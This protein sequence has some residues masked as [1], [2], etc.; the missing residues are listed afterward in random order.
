M[1]LHDA[2]RDA[3]LDQAGD[4]ILLEEQDR[5]RFNRAQITEALPLVD[6]A[7]R[8]GPEPF[9]IEAAIAA[10]HCRAETAEQTDWPQ[11]LGLYDVLGRLQPSPVVSLNRAVALAMVRGVKPALAVVDA[12]ANNSDLDNYYLLYATR[13]DLLRRLGS[14]SEAAKN[15]ARAL[16]LVSNDSERR[17]L[18]RRLREVGAATG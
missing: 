18:E 1:L 9:A 12:L 17:F 5:S 8:G 7:L 15:Y 16:E 3:R 6:E 14:F 13:A 11:I 10:L 4:I 2:R